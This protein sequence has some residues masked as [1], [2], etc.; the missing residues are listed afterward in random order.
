M[1]KPPYV[2]L[3][4]AEEGTKSAWLNTMAGAL[5][6]LK[7]AYNVGINATHIAP[8]QQGTIHAS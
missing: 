5:A 8:I 3:A 7:K 1:E 4:S 6:F 2:F